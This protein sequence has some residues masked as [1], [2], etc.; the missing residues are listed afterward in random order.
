LTY[1]LN[2]IFECVESA[3]NNKPPKHEMVVCDLEPQLLQLCV[4]ILSVV[5]SVAMV[6]A[7]FRTLCLRGAFLCVRG[8]RAALGSPPCASATSECLVAHACARCVFLTLG[9]VTCFCGL[10]CS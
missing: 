6:R 1:L 7:M 2:S 10:D 9:A 5:T 4:N 8:T 3:A